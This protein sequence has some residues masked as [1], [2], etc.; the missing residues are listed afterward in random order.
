MDLAITTKTHSVATI[1]RTL[2]AEMAIIRQVFRPVIC[3][4]DVEKNLDSSFLDRMKK[5]RD[6]VWKWPLIVV[7]VL[8]MSG[9]I[10]ALVCCSI[11]ANYQ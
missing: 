5:F 4:D 9:I 2:V 7:G 3:G 1:R 8:L 10:M 11:I 6:K